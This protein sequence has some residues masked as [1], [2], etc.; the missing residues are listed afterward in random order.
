MVVL[1]AGVSMVI[2]RF[3]FFLWCLRCGGGSERLKVVDLVDCDEAVWLRCWETVVVVLAAGASM[4]MRLV[5][6]VRWWSQVSGVVTEVRRWWS[7]KKSHNG[8]TVTLKFDNV[9]KN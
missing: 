6:V 9:T 1:A 3:I 8:L 7:Q 2:F 5:A 4:A